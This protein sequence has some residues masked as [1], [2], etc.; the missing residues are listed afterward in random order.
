MSR[1][2]VICPS[3]AAVCD[4]DEGVAC[5][6]CGAF[7]GAT[8]LIGS[9]RE[10]G[11]VRLDAPTIGDRPPTR[12]RWPWRRGPGD[13]LLPDA[14]RRR[15]RWRRI[16]GGL[17]VVVS[18]G[19]AA[20]WRSLDE[21]PPPSAVPGDGAP[22]LGEDPAAYD[23][24]EGRPTRTGSETLL[25]TVWG[26]AAEL[27]DD[28]GTWRQVT[29]AAIG[30]SVVALGLLA[31]DV[32][33]ERADEVSVAVEAD[34]IVLGVID[35]EV[36][37]DACAWLRDDGIGPQIVHTVTGGDCSADAAPTRGWEYVTP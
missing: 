3:C 10:P 26:P 20:W 6:A 35:L 11:P 17:M 31:A 12:H 2:S 5:R 36:G 30:E 28:W 27:Y 33:P 15:R 24:P 13:D 37:P 32:S 16:G 4:P 1:S 29:P 23:R 14:E 22:V 9:A 8:P 19:T 25:V 21:D 34:R 18:L 7:L